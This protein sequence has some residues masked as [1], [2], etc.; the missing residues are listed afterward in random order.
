[1]WEEEAQ[2]SVLQKYQRITR[3]IDAYKV[4]CSHKSFQDI[5]KLT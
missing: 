5:K 3:D 2:F 1:M 4:I